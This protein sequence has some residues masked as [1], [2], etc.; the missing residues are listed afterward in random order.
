MF[1]FSFDNFFV[2]MNG[3]CDKNVIL[4]SAF[5]KGYDGKCA[6]RFS[7]TLICL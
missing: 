4:S 2:V 5:S 6:K 7:T 1:I 3:I